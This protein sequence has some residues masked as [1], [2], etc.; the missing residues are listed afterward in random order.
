MLAVVYICQCMMAT[1]LSKWITEGNWIYFFVNRFPK[2][3]VYLHTGPE[4]KSDPITYNIMM[5]VKELD[6]NGGN[7]MGGIDAIVL[8]IL[9][10]G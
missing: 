7:R 6:S 5:S 8:I 1:A 10:M 4:C 2:L 3:Y 9:L